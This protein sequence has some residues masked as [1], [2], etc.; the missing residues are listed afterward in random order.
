M[1]LC[2][3]LFKVVYINYFI[4]LSDALLG[5]QCVIICYHNIRGSHGRNTGVCDCPSVT[6]VLINVHKLM[7][8]K[9]EQLYN[10]SIVLG[11]WPNLLVLCVLFTDDSSYS[12]IEVSSLRV[13]EGKIHWN[14]GQFLVFFFFGGC[15]N[16]ILEKG[17]LL[18]PSVNHQVSDGIQ[19]IRCY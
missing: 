14:C 15:S 8:R 2:L 16:S 6:A 3:W 9:H 5:P 1:V 18:V 11:A 17:V 13:R 4:V 19:H 12:S 10:I 7:F